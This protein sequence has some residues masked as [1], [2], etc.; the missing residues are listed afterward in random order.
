[1]DRTAVIRLWGATGWII[2][3]MIGRRQ[4]VRVVTHQV[5]HD[6][7]NAT[8]L[9]IEHDRCATVCTGAQFQ[10]PIWVLIIEWLTVQAVKVINGQ[11]AVIKKHYMG[12]VLPSNTLA[13]RTVAGVVV[14][15]I[16]IRVGVNMVAPSSILMRHVFLLANLSTKYHATG[17]DAYHVNGI[18]QFIIL[19][20]ICITL[21]TNETTTNGEHHGATKPVLGQACKGVC[22]AHPVPWT[23][24]CLTRR[25]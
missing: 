12:C 8:F 11:I 10:W 22:V 13:D 19:I 23:Q 21:A 6:H 3:G 24:V 15:W 1:M 2:K 7:S 9:V 20:C 5:W 14:D 18:W 17:T 25:A 16:A 4:A